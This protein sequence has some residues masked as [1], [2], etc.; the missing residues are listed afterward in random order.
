MPI[1]SREANAATVSRVISSD[2]LELIDIPLENSLGYYSTTV[3]SAGQAVV[4]YA[5]NF[6]GTP[7]VWGGSAPGGFDCS[8][9]CWYVYKQMGYTLN[10]V[11]ND[12]MNNGTYVSMGD[13]QPGDLVFFGSGGYAGH[14]GIYV[15]DGNFIHAPQ[16]G[17]YVKISNLYT[18][19]YGNRFLG[20]RRI[21]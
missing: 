13:L 8:G 20:G 11:A 21:V 14:V 12:Q 17:D 19:N 2:L 15:S 18:T 3:S 1:A 4:D 7:Y 5:M 16:T 9:L 6:L 10:R